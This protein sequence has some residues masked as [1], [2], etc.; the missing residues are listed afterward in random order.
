MQWYFLYLYVPWKFELEKKR[1]ML[2]YHISHV[3]N[4]HVQAFGYL[5][6]GNF[7]YNYICLI[8]KYCSVYICHLILSSGLNIFL[9]YIIDA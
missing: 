6:V 7:V 8:E 5:F 2:A 1:G 4:L 9:L 3:H